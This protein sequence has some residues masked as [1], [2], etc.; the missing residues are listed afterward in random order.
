M[1]N[2]AMIRLVF[3]FG[4]L[5]LVSCW[6]IIAAR[7]SLT[8]PKFVRWG[9]NFGIV[10]INT[11]LVKFVFSIAAVGV[12][13]AAEK[14][15]WG[16]LNYFD[17]SHVPSVL[18]GILVLDLAIYFQHLM[19]HAVPLFWRLHMVHHADL[20]VD[21][22]TGLRFHP[23]E[24]VIS[25]GIKMGIVAALGPPV[26]AVLV[27]EIALNGTS[28]FNHGNIQLPH[29][30]DRLLRMFVVTPDMHRVHHS[31]V[32][33]ETN[34]NFGFNLTWWDR[35]FGTYRAQPVAGHKKMTI[36]L[37]QFRKP[38][39]LILP[40]LLILPFTGAKGKYSL[41][42]IGQDPKTILKTGC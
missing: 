14:N 15:G 34:S 33:R 20:D 9:N 24:M 31:V 11:I 13:V 26:I 37:S 19:F 29:A 7:R 42:S 10:V 21:V 6:E 30:L 22:T 8:V 39:E 2:E 25:M 36:G 23:I 5:L 38:E 41:D 27:F 32:I 16:L 12:S 35:L 4:I 17:I 3:F 18:I 1:Q 28:M 40:K